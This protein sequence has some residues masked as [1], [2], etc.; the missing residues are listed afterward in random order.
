MDSRALNKLSRLFWLGR[1]C[2]RVMIESEIMMKVYD[3]EIDG[4]GFDYVSFCCDLEIPNVYTSSDDFINRFMFDEDDPYSIL[5]S[6]NRA[7]DN[8]IVLRNVI[9]SEA[10]SYVEIALN[11]LESTASGVAPLLD[12]QNAIDA[13]YA[14]RGCIDGNLYDDA[15]RNA[16]KCGESVEHID[17][18]VRLQYHTYK[19]PQEMAMLN[20]RMQHTPLPRDA[21]CLQLLL[22]LAPNP[23]PA[24]NRT[25]LIDCIEGLFRDV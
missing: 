21:K 16:I 20:Y 6:M 24:H 17:V 23:D 7:Y 22:D 13:L 1:Y 10:L 19:L 14:F 12:L 8:A 18:H 9:S 5:S 3:E 4:S 15:C 11:T 2:A 25:I